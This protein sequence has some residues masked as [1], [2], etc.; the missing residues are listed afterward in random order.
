[1]PIGF[2]GGSISD[3]TRDEGRR[4]AARARRV[5]QRINRAKRPG[6][7]LTLAHQAML[8]CVA[9]VDPKHEP[10]YADR[11]NAIRDALANHG[12]WDEMDE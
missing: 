6:H 4:R 8:A 7:E 12:R 2:C 5:E 10:D 3:F 1:V 11:L 9:S